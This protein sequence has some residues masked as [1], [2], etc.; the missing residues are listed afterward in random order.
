MAP[1]ERMDVIVD[2][3][4]LPDG[5]IIRILNTAPDAPFG[6]FPDI[7]ADPGTTGQVMQFVVNRLTCPELKTDTARPAIADYTLPAEKPSE[8]VVTVTRPLSL[9]EEE[10]AQVCVSVSPSGAV[11]YLGSTDPHNRN[12][13][14]DC[15]LMGGV[16]QAPKAAV[17]GTIAKD[18]NA[19]NA[20]SPV[21]YLWKQPITEKPL[22]NATEVWEFYN[23]TVDGHPIHMH[24]VAYEIIDRQMIDPISLKLIPLSNTDPLPNELGRKDTVLSYPGEVV[25]VKSTFDLPGL[26]VW[27][28]HI[29]EHEDN[30]MMRPFYVS[31]EL[32][33]DLPDGF[34]RP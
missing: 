7:A 32:D 12:I 13:A 21:P 4:G 26:Y 1:A 3:S 17:L 11:T 16:P 2:F 8:T 33:G 24:L 6:G 23:M 20:V 18:P 28:C 10:S 27:H 34:P 19:G 22:L 9:N 15:A 14:A 5:T 30:E 31:D 29:V 25:R